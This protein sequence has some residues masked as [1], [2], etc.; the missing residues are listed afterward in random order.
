MWASSES[1]GEVRIAPRM[2]IAAVHCVLPS[3]LAMP[4]EPRSSLSK[5]LLC[6]GFIHTLATYVTLDMTTAWYSCLVNLDGVPQ[7]APEMRRIS[8][9]YSVPLPRA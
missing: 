2:V 1:S 3:F 4:M 7:E 9:A 5:P 6:V 8:M